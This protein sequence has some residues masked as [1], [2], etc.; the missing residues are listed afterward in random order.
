VR[1]WHI[2]T[3]YCTVGA[4]RI[5][6]SDWSQRPIEEVKIGDEVVGWEQVGGQRVLRRAKVI[7]R[8][9]HR[10]QP[11]N[12]YT[13]NTGRSVTCT[14]D[15]KWWRGPWGSGAE[16][17]HL[18]IPRRPER[19]HI[20]VIGKPD[21]PAKAKGMSG[22][23]QLLV[24]TQQLETRDAG[25]IAGMYDGEGTFKKN[26]N[27]PS[28]AAVITQSMLN[29][30][31]I[32]ELR[33]AFTRLRFEF[34]EA[35]WK[36]TDTN[37]D[38]RDRMTHDRCNFLING[39]WSERYRFLVEIN[40]TKRQP[41]ADSLFAKLTTEGL[42]LVQVEAQEPQDVH[43]LETE[44]GNYVV[45]GLCSS[46]SFADTYGQIMERG[47][48]IPRIYPA[49]HDGTMNGRLVFMSEKRWQDKVKKQRSTLA[50]QMLQNPLSGKE[51]MFEPQWIARWEVRPEVMNVYIMVDPSSGR[52]KQSDRTAMAVIGV[53]A[54]GKK[55]LL[56]GV[57][58]RMAL[59]ER[60]TWLRMFYIKWSAARGV[61]LIKVGYERYGLQSDIEHF[62]LEMQKP[63]EVQF[64]IIELNTTA[65]G[66]GNQGKKSRVGRLEPDVRLGNL[67]LPAMIAVP[68][69]GDCFWSISKTESRIVV[70]PV[71]RVLKNGEKIRGVS[72]NM[73]AMI[74]R[75]FGHLTARPIERKNEDGKPYDATR[76]LVDEMIFFPFAPRD[77]FVD[78][79]SRIFDMGISTPDPNDVMGGDHIEFTEFEDA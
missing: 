68:G 74:D 24:P 22:V 32:N 9:V 53:G 5:T 46:N 38:K 17:N 67:L 33:A 28:G 50:A 13:F 18:Q 45:E 78:C 8:G 19:S 75:G 21:L 10:Q 34:S 55:Y 15:H 42:D 60:W 52:H 40:P 47:A 25:W 63:G 48:L 1:V 29:P 26:P 41:I 31:I 51:N 16:Y 66:V 11:V 6:M 35:W 61:R 69:Q 27:H 37:G 79:V 54:S 65:D 14:A 56:D 64:E 77:D 43:W 72:R 36:A 71:E 49:T 44:T 58:H 2:G 20:K 59:S 3:R 23:R 73:K 76:T 30:H 70:E 7:N 57:C 4:M 62:N 39:G 12:R